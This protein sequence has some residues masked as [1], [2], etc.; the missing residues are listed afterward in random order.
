VKTSI[1]M[2]VHG[3]SAVTRRCLDWLARDVRDDPNV[4]TIVV[5]DGS[6]DD[7]RAVVEAAGWPRLLPHERAGGF[8]SACNDG[9]AAAA[10]DYIVFLNNDTE[11]RPD[12]LG[13]LVAYADATPGAAAV[14]P[15][16]LY[17]NDTV[18][19]AGIVISGDRLPRHVYR[20]FAADH[21]A[22][23]RSRRFQAVTAACM[24]VRRDAFQR[25]NGFD[26]EFVNGFEDVDL[27]LRLGRG[28]GEVHYC[29]DSVLGHFEATTR[30]EDVAAFHANA[31]R[32]LARW[33]NL[34]QPDDLA[35]YAEDGLMQVEPGDIYPLRLIV[36]PELAIVETDE[37][38]AF[39]LLRVR[40][41]Q[42]FELLKQTTFLGA[43]TSSERK[44]VDQ[45]PS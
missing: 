16:L 29:A 13:R 33:G 34:V 27:C 19:H 39:K 30:G 11:G 14:A 2:P 23:S 40:S 9:A 4:E 6:P 21:P 8:A 28:G 36:S 37:V 32:Y 42:V 24:L 25:I 15:K 43:A 20:G 12:W 7:T 35:T 18:Q 41:R 1:V 5:D 44:G 22:V 31:K 3:K 26:T 17:P 38:D 10:G 45:E